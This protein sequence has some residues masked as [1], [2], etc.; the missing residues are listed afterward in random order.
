MFIIID[1]RSRLTY[2]SVPSF[3]NE[4]TRTCKYVS[5]TDYSVE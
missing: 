5:T 1:K 4:N 2:K 3:S